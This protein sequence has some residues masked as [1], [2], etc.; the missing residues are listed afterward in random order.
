MLEKVWQIMGR[1]RMQLCSFK[2]F[3]TNFQ[4]RKGR[5]IWPAFCLISSLCLWFSCSLSCILLHTLEVCC[6]NSSF[7]CR[8]SQSA[9]EVL[10]FADS[11]F[12][13]LP[14]PHSCCLSPHS[15]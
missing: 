6:S 10:P 3:A 13:F 1:F 7:S 14:F 4:G 15:C 2:G 5:P 9:C 11:S 8:F 12:L